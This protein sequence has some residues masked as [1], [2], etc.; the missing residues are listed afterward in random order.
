MLRNVSGYV[1]T[2]LRQSRRYILSSTPPQVSPLFQLERDDLPPEDERHLKPVRRDYFSDEFID[3]P[4]VPA[5][6]RRAVVLPLHIRDYLVVPIP[7]VVDS[8]VPNFM[9]LGSGCRQVLADLGVLMDRVLPGA[10]YWLKGMM[11][12][13]EV[14]VISPLAWFAWSVP[15]QQEGSV[16]VGDIRV[17]LLGLNGLKALGGTFVL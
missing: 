13:G 7:F 11:R 3:S 6:R 17:N 16:V 5:G 12:R 4:I 14:R 15:L 1:R 10:P 2:L 9:Y 8:G